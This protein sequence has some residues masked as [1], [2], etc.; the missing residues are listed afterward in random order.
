MIFFLANLKLFKEKL[1]NS[2]PTLDK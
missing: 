1:R 2:W